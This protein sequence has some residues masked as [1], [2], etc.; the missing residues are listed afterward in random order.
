MPYLQIFML[1]TGLA[2]CASP[3]LALTAADLAGKTLTA[4]N[5]KIVLGPDGAM[6]GKVGKDTLAGSWS[7]KGD[8]MCRTI[9]APERLAGSA[10]Q[11]VVLSDGKLS[12]T[13]EDGSTIV[14]AVK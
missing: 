5:T 12:V 6:S 13:R 9:T 4:K 1:S 11:A 7:V 3:L 14:Y 10:C 2:L 8:K